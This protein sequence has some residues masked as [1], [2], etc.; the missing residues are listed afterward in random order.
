MLLFEFQHDELL[1]V[2]HSSG[3]A[4]GIIVSEEP[5]IKYPD[6]ATNCFIRVFFAIRSGNLL[7][8]VPDQIF[9]LFREKDI[10]FCLFVEQ[11]DLGHIQCE[12]RIGAHLQR[13]AGI[14]TGGDL[15]AF[16]IEVQ[17]HFSAEHLVN[18]DLGFDNAVGMRSKE[19]CVVRNILRTDAENNG[20]SVVTAINQSLFLCPGKLIE[21][22]NPCLAIKLYVHFPIQQIQ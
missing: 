3:R 22:S 19:V 15:S 8:Q 13:S 1:K 6:E 17:E 14:D 18:I 5:I 21:K 4:G 7:Q 12:G 20:L 2:F 10:L 11:M 16:H 9:K